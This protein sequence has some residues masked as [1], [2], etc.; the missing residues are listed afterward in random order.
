MTKQN[1][2][3]EKLSLWWHHYLPTLKAILK[4]IIRKSV[5]MNAYYTWL[6]RQVKHLLLQT[7]NKEE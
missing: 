3:I 2:E 4:A 6:S 5:T 1:N 7:S